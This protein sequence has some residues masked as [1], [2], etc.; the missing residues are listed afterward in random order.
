MTAT[1]KKSTASVAFSASDD[2]YEAQLQ[3]AAQ[4][5]VPAAAAGVIGGSAAGTVGSALTPNLE[6]DAI[7]RFQRGA[8]I[9]AM[10]RARYAIHSILS[11]DEAAKRY[12]APASFGAGGNIVHGLVTV[13]RFP[14]YVLYGTVDS[15][16][17]PKTIPI[18]FAEASGRALGAIAIGQTDVLRALPW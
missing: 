11:L 5:P 1:V 15:G 10:T 13:R 9:P 18:Y 4:D 7:V 2:W 6:W 17:G 8:A 12:P 3:G 16:T 14:S